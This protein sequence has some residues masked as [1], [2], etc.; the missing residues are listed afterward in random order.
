MVDT[1]STATLSVAPTQDYAASSCRLLQAGHRGYGSSDDG[2][3]ERLAERIPVS[4]VRAADARRRE[5]T[6]YDRRRCIDVKATTTAT[7]PAWVTGLLCKLIDPWG[8][9]LRRLES[10]SV[11]DR[12]RQVTS[13]CTRARPP[14]R[15]HPKRRNWP[16]GA[17][18]P[19]SP[20]R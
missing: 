5:H 12:C 18:Q 20:G 10:A 9:L 16:T 17:I 1:S 3:V 19:C 8:K 4:E 14:T 6:D 13:C 7:V 15:L 2:T 11:L